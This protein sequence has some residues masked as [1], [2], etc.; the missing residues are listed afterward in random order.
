MNTL[1]VLLH[2][3]AGK[4]EASQSGPATYDHL[5]KGLGV[6]L[7]PAGGEHRPEELD[8]AVV[9]NVLGCRQG[10][11]FTSS[12]ACQMPMYVALAPL[13]QEHVQRVLGVHESTTINRI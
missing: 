10:C 2:Q 8:V 1:F 3:C 9:Q 6:V 12:V 13:L 7:F 4:R 5:E 11:Q